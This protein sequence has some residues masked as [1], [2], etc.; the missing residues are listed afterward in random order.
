MCIALY[1]GKKNLVP[2]LIRGEQYL[3]L[4]LNLVQTRDRQ[5]YLAFINLFAQ[6]QGIPIVI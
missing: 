4:V 3:A 1:F 2:I 5:V 6:K